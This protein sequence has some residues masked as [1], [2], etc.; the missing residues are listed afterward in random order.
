MVTS[1]QRHTCLSHQLSR[2]WGDLGV[3]RCPI[4]R[5]NGLTSRNYLRAIQVGRL[6][7]Y[8]VKCVVH[9]RWRAPG[10]VSSV[11][12][13]RRHRQR[14]TH[15]HSVT[16]VPRGNLAKKACFLF[17]R[18]TT[19]SVPVSGARSQAKA[20]H[21][22]R[23]SV[24]PQV[25]HREELDMANKIPGGETTTRGNKYLNLMCRGAHDQPR[26]EN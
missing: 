18:S 7:A 2:R 12:S 11:L 10:Q 19:F 21:D 14:H 25:P 1:G 24:S 23:A 5:F 13:Q 4:K 3:G 22:P 15:T 6:K 9:F 16:Q 8:F 20:P 17:A 26:E